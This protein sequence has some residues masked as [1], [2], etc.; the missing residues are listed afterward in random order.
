LAER[1]G[2]EL[3][4]TRV[5][6]FINAKDKDEHIYVVLPPVKGLVSRSNVRVLLGFLQTFGVRFNCLMYDLTYTPKEWDVTSN[7]QST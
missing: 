2:N 4:M 1:S 5:E 6:V 7:T 3:K